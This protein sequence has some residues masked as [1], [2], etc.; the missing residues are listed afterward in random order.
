MKHRVEDSVQAPQITGLDFSFFSCKIRQH[1]QITSNILF[2][3]SL[4]QVSTMNEYLNV[5]ICKYTYVHIYAHTYTQKC[6]MATSNFPKR[7]TPAKFLFFVLIFLWFSS[8]YIVV[9]T[10]HYVSFLGKKCSIFLLTGI[11]LSEINL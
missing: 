7:F 1:D 5:Y 8:S 9:F 6:Y 3:L 4:L 2:T 11:F 10:Y